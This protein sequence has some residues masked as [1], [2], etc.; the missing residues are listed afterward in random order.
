MMSSGW[1]QRSRRSARRKAKEEKKMSF[2]GRVLTAMV[3]PLDEAGN[4][5]LSQAAALAR[6]LAGSGSDGGV[7][8][9]TPRGA[10]PLARDEENPPPGDGEGGVGGSA[11]VGGGHG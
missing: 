10:P 11:G 7:G 3:T 4:V 1:G 5:D 9:G 2:F 8:A 6:R